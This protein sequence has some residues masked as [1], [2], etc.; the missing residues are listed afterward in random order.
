MKVN[1]FSDHIA[2]EVGGTT[3]GAWTMVYDEGFDIQ[4]DGVDYFGFSKFYKEGYEHKS[5]CSSTLMGWY[6]DKTNKMQGCWKGH[7]TD[8]KA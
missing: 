2:K 7:K 1:L 5:D 3:E 4:L 8:E 6:H